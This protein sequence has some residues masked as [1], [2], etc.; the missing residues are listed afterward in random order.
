MSEDKFK[1]IIEKYKNRYELNL[2]QFNQFLTSRVEIDSYQAG[3]VI[4]YI[5]NR[6]PNVFKFSQDDLK[7]YINVIG[8]VQKGH[9]PAEMS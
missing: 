3:V 7:F 4:D 8:A 5:K 6:D 2:D 9:N 1:K